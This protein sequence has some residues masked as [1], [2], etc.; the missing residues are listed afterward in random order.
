MAR[1]PRPGV[2][3]GFPIRG[4]FAESHPDFRRDLL[5]LA[6]PRS[7]AAG[8]PIY[9]AG[10]AGLDVFAV[11]SGVVA[12]Q[13]KFTHADAVLMHLLW[14]GE[15]FGTVPVLLAGSRRVTAVA[16]TDVQI[17]R[18]PG[19]E[20][21]ALLRR[22]P[23]WSTEL[24]R[25]LIYNMDLAVQMSADLLIR[26]APARCA[27]VLLRLAGR[28]WASGPEA[29]LPAAIPATQG[30][31]AMLCN[32]SRNTFSRIVK[33]FC[34]RGLVTLNYGSLTVNDPVRLRVAADAG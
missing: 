11:S 33:A 25:D 17:L 12:L 15:W 18:V 9:Q 2:P 26:H 28:R 21:R 6:R 19:E 14:P 31:L 30:E 13:G 4:W 16:R 22:R 32:V 5:A 7:Y 24:G 23:A 10:D 34:A 3:A 1:S 20:L 29:D 8:S 27:A